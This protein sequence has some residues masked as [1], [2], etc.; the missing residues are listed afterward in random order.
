MLR[1]SEE[2]I[3]GP[4]LGPLGPTF[5]PSVPNLGTNN[6]KQLFPCMTTINSLQGIYFPPTD[7]I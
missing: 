6:C 1:E 2:M 7:V 3:V 5:R 4:N